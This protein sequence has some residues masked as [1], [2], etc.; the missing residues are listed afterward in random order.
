MSSSNFRQSLSIGIIR[1]HN[2]K[3]TSFAAF[4]HAS[5]VGHQNLSGWEQAEGHI[6]RADIF[7]LQ[8]RYTNRRSH[9]RL[10]FIAC[11]ERQ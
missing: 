3:E 8:D 9:P 11:C 6:D 1:Q 5:G 10:R 2:I 7:S 4:S